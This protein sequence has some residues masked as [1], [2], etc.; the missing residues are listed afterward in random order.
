MTG[1]GLASEPMRSGGREPEFIDAEAG[2]ETVKA[3]RDVLHRLRSTDGERVNPWDIAVL[4]ASTEM[5]QGT[6]TI[7]PQL[8]AEQLGV[9]ETSVDMAPQDTSIVPDSGPTVASRTAMVKVDDP[10]VVGVPV[11]APL[12][13]SASPSGS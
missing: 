7:F 1:G 3:L 6:K 2:A 9:A 4:T 5:G 13:W 11:S 12:A 10:S 8:C